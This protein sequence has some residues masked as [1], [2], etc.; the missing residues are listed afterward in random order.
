MDSSGL[1]NRARSI[2]ALFAA[3]G[4]ITFAASTTTAQS[5]QLN[6]EGE[7]FVFNEFGAIIA[8]H[9]GSLQVEMILME[10]DQR[11][12]AYKKVD[13]K[14]GD[15]VFMINGKRA[16]S[17]SD[18]Q[19]IYD[20][21]KAGDNI[22]LAV[23]RDKARMMVSFPKADPDA[24]GGH[25]M[26]IRTATVGDGADITPIPGLGIVVSEAD[27]NVKVSGVLPM[28]PDAEFKQVFEEGDIITEF[29]DKPLTSAADLQSRLEE[30]AVGDVM[31]VE[32]S[33][34]GGTDV[35]K[36]AKPEPPKLRTVIQ[37]Q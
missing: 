4:V 36:F 34:E 20:A 30:I 22:T 7:P 28:P 18:I 24:P 14:Q 15:E 10:P 21:L 33:R 16:K 9:D 29:Q 27:G 11:E 35:F 1:K 5:T 32:V 37:K 2:A 12:A 19:E 23:R 17:I 8:E 31:T 13:L 26:M 3:A 6:I 25:R